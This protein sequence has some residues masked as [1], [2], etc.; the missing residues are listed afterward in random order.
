[1]FEVDRLK[2]LGSLPFYWMLSLLILTKC[3]SS[4]SLM[5]KFLDMIPTML[6][7]LFRTGKLEKGS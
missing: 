7:A 2:T 6:P 1:M 5:M 3:F 4:I